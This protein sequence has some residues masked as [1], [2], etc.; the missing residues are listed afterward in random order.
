MFLKIRSF[1]L[2]FLGMCTLL[3]SCSNFNQNTN[4]AKIAHIYIKLAYGYIEQN[5]LD[6][7]KQKLS[8]AFELAPNLPETQDAMAYL[9]ARLGENQ[10]AEQHYQKA[11][12]LSHESPQ[13]LNNYGAFLCKIGRFDE[14]EQCFLKV[15]ANPWYERPQDA[16]EN[17]GFCASMCAKITKSPSCSKKAD[18]FLKKALLY[19]PLR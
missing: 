18:I 13:I 19:H 3:I 6:R 10:T 4:N 15:I 1:A 7:A 2:F 14:A 5:N 17:A 16:Y 8:K 11:L 12:V 9:Y